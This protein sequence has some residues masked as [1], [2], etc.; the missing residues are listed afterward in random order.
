MRIVRLLLGLPF[1][2][3]SN[4]RSKIDIFMSILRNFI[5]MPDTTDPELRIRAI[6]A[7]AQL[8][9]QTE[10]SINQNMISA[11]QR[12]VELR[13]KNQHNRRS[14][15]LIF[16]AIS[17]LISTIFTLFYFKNNLNSEITLILTSLLSIFISLMTDIYFFEFGSIKSRKY[18]NNNF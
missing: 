15:F 1:G 16:F 18:F 11:R 9:V 10:H 5:Q 12:D 8:C 13:L 17:G 3:Q 2:I 14:D 6:G 4:L 7:I